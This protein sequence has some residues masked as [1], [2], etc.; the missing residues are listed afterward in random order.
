MKYKVFSK[1]GCNNLYIQAGLT[2]GAGNNVGYAND[3]TTGV[4]AGQTAMMTLTITEK[5]AS[6]IQVN[7]IKCY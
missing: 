6:K 2:D 3:M 1:D 5:S 7:E 4:A